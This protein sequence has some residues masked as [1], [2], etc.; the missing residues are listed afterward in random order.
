[1]RTWGWY[2]WTLP[3]WYST[4][5][6]SFMPQVVPQI[7]G[8]VQAYAHAH[9]DHYLT[10]SNFNSLL[11]KMITPQTYYIYTY[12]TASCTSS[13]QGSLRFAPNK[14]YENSNYCIKLDHALYSINY[15]NNTDFSADSN[16]LANVTVPKEATVRGI[17]GTI[18]RS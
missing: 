1:M 11:T 2:P 8:A 17:V 9:D 3:E 13:I 6:S 16:K 4:H 7:D 18:V 12:K 15:G 14:C 5:L 10:R